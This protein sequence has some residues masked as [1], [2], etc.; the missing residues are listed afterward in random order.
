MG[1]VVRAGPVV[2]VIIVDFSI[3]FISMGRGFRTNSFSF[4]FSKNCDEEIFFRTEFSIRVANRVKRKRKIKGGKKEREGSNRI[5]EIDHSL[6]LIQFSSSRVHCQAI[7]NFQ[8]CYMI[9]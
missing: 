3:E 5:E 4:F 6:A 7:C 2:R 9:V 8:P 1:N